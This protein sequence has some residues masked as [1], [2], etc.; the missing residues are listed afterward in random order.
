MILVRKNPSL[1]HWPSTE[2][3]REELESV[4]LYL[5]SWDPG[6]KLNSTS[7]EAEPSAQ[8]FLKIEPQLIYLE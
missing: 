8:F 5:S 1:N 2:T 4:P 3:V 6:Q 7:G